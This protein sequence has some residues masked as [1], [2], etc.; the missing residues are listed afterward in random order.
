MLARSALAPAPPAAGAIDRTARLLSC[1]TRAQKTRSRAIAERSSTSEVSSE[2]RSA[3]SPCVAEAEARNDHGPDVSG[4][5]TK[6][7]SWEAAE[8]EGDRK[9][10]A[11]VCTR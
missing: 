6:T 3:S 8:S 9:Q 2:Q 1:G 11:A 5:Q 7:A 10:H 4:R